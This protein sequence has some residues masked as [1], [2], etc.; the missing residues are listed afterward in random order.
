MVAPIRQTVTIRED[1][2]VEIV[3]PELRRGDIAEVTV[4]VG[5]SDPAAPA[6]SRIEA[7]NRLQTHLRLDRQTAQQW[8][9]SVNE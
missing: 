9:D 1:G 6:N 7:L 3:A 2:K 8:I 4:M 5:S